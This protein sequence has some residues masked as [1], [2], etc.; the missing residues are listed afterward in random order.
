MRKRERK[1]D[2]RLLPSSGAPGVTGEDSPFSQE[3][4]KGSGEMFT[5]GLALPRLTTPLS[6][7]TDICL[8]DSSGRSIGNKGFFVSALLHDPK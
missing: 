6:K 2:A 3:R 1:Q 5:T 7:F 4:M 8:V